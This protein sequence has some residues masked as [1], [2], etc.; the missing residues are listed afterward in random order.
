M[1][2]TLIGSGNLA[3]NLGHALKDAGAGI[4][5]IYSRTKEHALR[6]ADELRIEAYT[7]QISAINK[8][9]DVYIVSVKDDA[10]KEVGQALS[11]QLPDKLIVHTAGSIPMDMLP[12]EHRGVFY[13][14]QTFTRQRIVPF[15]PI[16]IFIEASN[17]EDLQTLRHLAAMLSDCVIDLSSD[18][19][20]WLHIA[21]VFCCNFTNHMATLSAWLLEKHD[22]PFSVMLPL[23]EETVRKL[24]HLPPSEAQTGPAV[25]GDEVVIQRHVQM[26]QDVDE[27]HLAELYQA[28]STSIR[29]LKDPKEL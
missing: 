4:L 27:P 22:I 26:L 3:T 6:L 25:R 2:V 28:L 10:L 14:M 20:K 9:S 1:T 24:H 13:P 16:P 23:M 17:T 29:D 12:C 15:K 21:A 5:Q 11:A 18:D 7:T 8:E 19:R